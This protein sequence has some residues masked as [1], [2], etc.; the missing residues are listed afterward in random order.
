MIR[1]RHRALVVV[2]AILLLLV[3]G[4]IV[5]ADSPVQSQG[6]ANGELLAASH[7]PVYA[8]FWFRLPLYL[9]AA[10]C[11]WLAG[12]YLLQDSMIFPT[13]MIP[14][15]ANEPDMGNGRM[16]QIQID[17]GQV[18]AYLC[19]APSAT[20][21]DPAPLA[22]YFHGNAELIDH[23]GDIAA[24]YLDRGISVLLV[25]YRGYGRSAGK[26]SQEGIVADAVRFYDEITKLPEIDKARI[27]FHGRSLGGAVAAQLAAQRKPAAMILESTFYSVQSVAKS[28]GAPGFLARHPFRTD[29]VVASIDIPILIFHGSHDNVIPTWHSRNLKKLAPHAEYAEFPCGHNDFPGAGNY[30]EYKQRIDRFLASAGLLMQESR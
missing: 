5:S 24:T 2:I 30:G 20:A 14:P 3:G 9:L 12:L 21:A 6:A 15:A 26:P 10:Y 17:D 18:E 11:S 22:L 25:E 16:L 7:R 28:Y 13:D 29:R 4:T 23:Q 1:V 27:I 8:R 19:L